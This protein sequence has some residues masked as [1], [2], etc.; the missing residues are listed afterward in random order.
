[1]RTV[2]TPHWTTTT[3]RR[4]CHPRRLSQAVSV[5]VEERLYQEASRIGITCITMS[6]RLALNEF[7]T[8]ELRLG[9]GGDGWE[10]KEIQ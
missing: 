6:Q 3:S 10:L 7:H 2:K 8:Q 9:G 5:D 4:R 1:M